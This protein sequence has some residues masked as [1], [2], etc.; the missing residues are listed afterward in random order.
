LYFTELPVC[1]GMRIIKPYF[2]TLI[3]VFTLLMLNQPITLSAEDPKE[4]SIRMLMYKNMRY[5]Y[6]IKCR[7]GFSNWPARII[8]DDK[9]FGVD[10]EASEIFSSE[11]LSTI[12]GL[13]FM[14]LNPEL[15]NLLGEHQTTFSYK[16]IGAMAGGEFK[17]KPLNITAKG[18]VSKK[19]LELYS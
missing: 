1:T 4:K 11:R 14:F 8:V 6:Q 16:G 2:K 7:T 3:A 12:P 13:N 18:R 15:L 10:S 5:E 9:L 17:T 19:L